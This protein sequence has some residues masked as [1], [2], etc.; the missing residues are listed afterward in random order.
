MINEVQYD[1]VQAGG[2]ADSEW[3]ELLNRTGW[4][5]DLTGWGIAD[6]YGGDYIASL[7][8]PPGGFAVIAAGD[9]FYDNFPDFSGDIVFIADGKIGNGLNNGGDRLVLTDSTGKTVD[10]LSYGNDA[11]IMLPPCQ[12]VAEGHS[13]ER[14]PA[15][16]D[17]DQASDFVDNGAPSPG[18]GLE[19]ATPTS[20]PMPEPT[21]APTHTSTPIPT[22]TPTPTDPHTYSPST[23]RGPT[24]TATP[25]LSP[26]LRPTVVPTQG[27]ADPS[28][29]GQTNIWLYVG[30]CSFLSLVGIASLAVVLQRRGQG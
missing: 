16:V 20:T 14:Q 27:Q 26:A 24:S 5:V 19:S 2:D 8:L 4:T 11:S 1:P 30:I 12:G 28:S 25:T 17:T 7:Q 21:P 15:G 3:L 13:L 22:I 29:A 18:Y 6:N 10:T 9:G 23:A